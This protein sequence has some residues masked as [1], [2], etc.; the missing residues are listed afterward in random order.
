MQIDS[1]LVDVVVILV[2]S[3]DRPLGIGAREERVGAAGVVVGDGLATAPDLRVALA[4][5]PLE[6]VLGDVGVRAAVAD[7]VGG[8]LQVFVDLTDHFL[9]TVAVAERRE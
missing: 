4:G 5:V 8:D 9:G 1:D 6:V 2:A 7:R 3:V